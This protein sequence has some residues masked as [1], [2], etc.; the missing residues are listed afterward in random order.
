MEAYVTER[1]LMELAT[2]LSACPNCQGQISSSRLRSGLPCDD[3]LPEATKSLESKA[4]DEAFRRKVASALKKNGRLLNYSFLVRLDEDKDEFVKLFRKLT[5]NQPWSAQ[6]TWAKRCIRGES[7][8]IIA[9][10][11]VGKT[12]F[13]TVLAVYMAIKHKR[14]LMVAPTALLARQIA[15]WVKKCCAI[16]GED[17]RVAEVHGEETA[18]EKRLAMQMLDDGTAQVV[19]LTAMGLS[20]IYERISGLSFSIA[21]VD[22]VDALLRKSMNIDR[23]LRLL[24]FN[25]EVQNLAV[26]AIKLRIRLA[27]LFAQG[28][29]GSQ[30]VSDAN[31]EYQKQ[32][33]KI[34]EYKKA[35]PGLGQLIVS[36]ATAR[37]KGIKVRMFRE[38][39]GFEAGSSTGY[40]RNIVDVQVKPSGN[41][42][43][44]VVKQVKRLGRGGLVFVS[45]EFGKP[46][47]QKLEKALLETDVK[48]YHTKAYF[49]KRVDEFAAS[50]L[51]VLIGTASYYGKLV[52]GIDLP[53]TV[54]YTLF[55]GVPKFKTRLEDEEASPLGL[56]RLLY[57]TADF[58]QNPLERQQIFEQAIKLRKMIQNLSPGD[59]SVV[60]KANQ[61]NKQLEGY[62]GKVQEEVG[63]GRRIFHVMLAHP[64]VLDR[65]KNSDQLIIQEEETGL[66]VL[67]P[68]VKTYIQASGRSSRLLGG[69]LTKGL[70]AVLV[71]NERVMSALR[72]AMQIASRNIKWL[73]HDEVD[74]EAILKE[75]D[76]DRSVDLTV[77][78]DKDLMKS[79]LLVVESPNK[80]RTIA[81]FF[82]RPGKIFSQ[83]RVFYEVAINNT[84]F[85]ISS[86]GGHI[87]DLPHAAKK[88][89]N[90]GVPKLNGSFV[91][92]YEYINRCQA[93][94]SQFTGCDAECP[95]CGSRSIR[96]SSEVVEALR[97][98]A[99]DVSNVYI[100]TD[101]DSEGEKIAWDVALLLS[102]FARSI[103]RAKFHEVTP[104][105]VLDAL[106]NASEIDLN[107]VT[108]QM[109]RRIDDRWIGYGLT[110]LLTAN[111][112]LI[113][114]GAKRRLRV[115]AGRVQ[116]PLLGWMV[117][118]SEANKSGKTRKFRLRCR[119]ANSEFVVIFR[120]PFNEI[121]AKQARS[122]V[123]TLATSKIVVENLVTAIAELKAPP[124]FTTDTVLAEASR[125][126]GWSV[127]EVMRRLQDLFETGLITYHRTDHTHVSST[128]IEIAR[129]YLES[130]WR[131]E[132]SVLFQ[133]RSW[134]DVGAHECIRPTKPLNADE[135]KRQIDLLQIPG[136]E[137]LD[138]RHIRL[139]DLIFRRFIAS[140][141]RGSK[142]VKQSAKL[143]VAGMETT[144]EGYSDVL[145]EGFNR[146]YPPRMV[147]PL[148]QGEA[149]DVLNVDYSVSSDS[150]LPTEGEAVSYMKTKG[151]GRPSTYASTIER[152]K[153][154]GYV[155]ATKRN[156][157]VA[158]NK[159]KSVYRFLNLKLV[160]L[161][162]IL[163]EIYTAEL[164]TKLQKIEGGEVDYRV[165]VDEC[166][167]DFELIK[168]VTKRVN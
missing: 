59:L 90:Y 128:G 12:T 153:R 122:L 46:F 110:E 126:F 118:K 78:L 117:Q 68:D 149:L 168:S 27:R 34:E 95:K 16:L 130:T 107:M 1:V 24:G 156:S 65:L 147:T 35:H 43:D 104:E 98:R 133:P 136:A 32:V 101:P 48:A 108:A 40:M 81:N 160:D 115:P 152:L 93:C 127:G 129:V 73:N 135:L 137:A 31:K 42:I 3:C 166:F 116:V 14:V 103:K 37:P 167:R 10:T 151:I 114:D 60:M 4:M 113:L 123:Q 63:E 111:Q 6:L 21:L 5:G 138:F 39:L 66:M 62:L 96:R 84:L 140:Q 155:F 161:K 26:E 54:R 52:R 41:M 15:S 109:V 20:R 120:K 134:G 11:G 89:T 50:K 141:M 28:F 64:G 55:V 29:G 18:K 82:G 69:K 53:Q 33:E 148:Q 47:M 100:A 61:E 157:L 2:F 99:S 19:V 56:I 83:G 145:E 85:T 76:A 91:P 44:D 17:I 124:P 71:D 154:H 163:D 67:T 30:E 86:T 23:V 119:K 165:V 45:K 58:T 9:P 72:R 159:G 106:E 158:T 92:M 22:D 139:Y 88:K 75:V 57:A 125:S 121:D 80:A 87:I 49:H 36:S 164:Q 146:L 132:W 51:D 13:L 131:N 38:L 7:F 150:P 142:L 144:L 77:K 25:D 79:A 112:S 8:A 94:N 102:P 105:A 143:S 74:F 162:S 70:S 97:R